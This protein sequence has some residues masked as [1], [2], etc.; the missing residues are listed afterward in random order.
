MRA[1]CNWYG[2]FQNVGYIVAGNPSFKLSCEPL[3]PVQSDI[4]FI[5]DSSSP[6]KHRPSTYDLEQGCQTRVIPLSMRV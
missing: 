4:C 3:N 1:A 5:T 2:T 6:P